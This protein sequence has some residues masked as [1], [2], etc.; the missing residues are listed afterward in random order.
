MTARFEE[1]NAKKRLAVIPLGMTRLRS[2][3]FRR[4]DPLVAVAA[5]RGSAWPPAVRSL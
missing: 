5:M 4:G 3:E 2:G 1:R